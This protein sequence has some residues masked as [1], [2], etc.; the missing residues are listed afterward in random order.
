MLSGVADETTK[1]ILVQQCDGLQSNFVTF[2]YFKVR[3]SVVFLD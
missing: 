3:I 2:F 1:N